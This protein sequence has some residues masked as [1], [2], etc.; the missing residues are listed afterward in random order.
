MFLHSKSDFK[1]T[2]IPHQ[3]KVVVMVFFCPGPQQHGTPCNTF[4][5]KPTCA[6]QHSRGECLVPGH[7]QELLGPAQPKINTTR[8]LRNTANVLLNQHC[9]LRTDTLQGFCESSFKISFLQAM[10][11]ASILLSPMMWI[12]PT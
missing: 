10:S 7:K 8:K 1:I 11:Q 9:I 12:I 4:G 2:S 3:E 6:S 5:T